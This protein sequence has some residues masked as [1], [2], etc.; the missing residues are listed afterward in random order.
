MSLFFTW[1]HFAGLKRN[2]QIA[3]H[4]VGLGI[5]NG[6]WL[7]EPQH[8]QLHAREN[9]TDS[10]EKAMSCVLP[11]THTHTHTHTERVQYPVVLHEKV[12]ALSVCGLA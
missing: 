11:L 7:A 8:N 12:A 1:F 5:F 4:L 10:A 6:F 2:K 9:R 3:P